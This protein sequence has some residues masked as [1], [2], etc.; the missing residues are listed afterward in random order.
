MHRTLHTIYLFSSLASRLDY[1]LYFIFRNTK[2]SKPVC[3]KKA[4]T[5]GS[6]VRT[7]LCR[8]RPRR[9]LS[10]LES[11]HLYLLCLTLLHT[12]STTPLGSS[13]SSC[14]SLLCSFGKRL[15]RTDDGLFN[16]YL[17]TN[18]ILTVTKETHKLVNYI[19]HKKNWVLSL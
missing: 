3:S 16:F 17:I 1:I 8:R 5:A 2:I 10:N 6:L 4:I 18:F 11:R 15:F 7:Q 12:I 9:T 19:Y 13:P 14:C